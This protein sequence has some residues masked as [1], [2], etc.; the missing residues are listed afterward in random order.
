ME[1]S[2][3][4]KD[5]PSNQKNRLEYLESIRPAWQEAHSKTMSL[6]EEMSKKEKYSADLKSGDQSKITMAYHRIY[7][8]NKSEFDRIN[9][10][11]DLI[12]SEMRESFYNIKS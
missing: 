10:E 2:R 1:N 11:R 9:E 7:K 6:I 12:I 3:D 8:D 5:T 4:W